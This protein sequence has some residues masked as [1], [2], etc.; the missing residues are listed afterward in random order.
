M[1]ASAT[2]L[3]HG[4]LDET[5][6]AEQQVELANWIKAS[7]EHA[8]QF[9][10]TVLLHDRLR[11][12]VLAGEEL[13][14]TRSVSEGQSAGTATNPSLTRRVTYGRHSRSLRTV[15]ALS[16]AL[17]LTLVLGLI[18][19]QSVSSPALAASVELQRIIQAS[20]AALDRT[21]L[22]TALEEEV[23][24]ETLPSTVRGAK[25]SVDGAL[26]HVRGPNQY[27]LV[28][29][30]ADGTEFITGSNEKTAWS[31][32]PRGRVR[33]SSDT[34]RFRG[35]VPGQ[36]Q[37]IPFIDMRN[38]LRQLQESYEI[39]LSP[40]K[41]P[42]GW[43]RMNATRKASATGGPKQVSIWYDATSGAVHRML[44]ERLPKGRGGPNSVLL[45][46]TDQSR[47]PDD[48][49]SHESHHASGRRIDHEP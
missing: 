35:A 15:L 16:S 10:E 29:Y 6:N 9:A 24:S 44:L 17:C 36:Q 49:F 2:D 26:L 1:S 27:V 37:A 42:E 5:L 22:V 41:T 45:E 21:Y 47:L 48:F 43:R 30:F 19:W 14:V 20:E 33:V 34:T 11:A 23:D 4:Y 18:F 40:E 38:S 8:R 3:I 28:R 39:D 32:P 46:L 25:P 13:L 12:Q 31:V 7:P